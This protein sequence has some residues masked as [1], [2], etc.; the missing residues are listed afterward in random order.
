MTSEVRK[1]AGISA[2]NLTAV[3]LALTV[4]LGAPT[5]SKS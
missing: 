4:T 3:A 2:P 1:R 5:A